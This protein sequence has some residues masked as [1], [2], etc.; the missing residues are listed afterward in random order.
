MT[1]LKKNYHWL[2]LVSCCLLAATCVG[3]FNNVYGVFY[4]SLCEALGV[5]RG[6]VAMHATISGLT[7]GITAPITVKI[8][9]KVKFQWMI[10]AAMILLA[11]S[12]VATVY[13][14]AVWQLNIIGVF[15]GIGCACISSTLLSIVLG[16]WFEKSYG[17]VVG[18]AFSFTGIAGA[19]L[20]PIVS[21]VITAAGYRTALLLVALLV[22][23][24]SLPGLL[25]CKETPVMLGLTAYGSQEKMKEGQLQA[26]AASVAK[27]TADRAN[28]I[29]PVTDKFYR[30]ATFWLIILMGALV[31]FSTSIAQH[32]TGFGESIGMGTA[33]G[34]TMLSAAMVGNISFKL[35][36]GVVSD[37][38]GARKTVMLFLGVTIVGILM[39]F[40]GRVTILMVVGAFLFGSSYG[41]AA[42]GMTAI[43]KITFGDQYGDINA[44]VALVG[45]A[46]AAVA[47]TIMGAIYDLSGSYA[48]VFLAVL[49]CVLVG[50]GC[51]LAVGKRK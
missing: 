13:A 27:K 36:L 6:V 44:I 10:L 47:L 35:L 12:T 51:M 7:T 48:G 4:T 28:D 18:I 16:N 43:S 42:V 34:V 11:G 50:V 39:V 8:M 49:A 20:S 9:K 30:T 25:F 33:V 5:G 29:R 37:R 2:I 21:A 15:R 22:V 3:L 41:V 38:L 31:S 40:L 19:M 24:L 26:A 45:N 32:F 17:T 23:V 14:N 1:L 46:C